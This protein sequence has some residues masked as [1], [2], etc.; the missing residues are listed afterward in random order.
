MIWSI[1]VGFV[2]GLL[3][4]AIKPGA[5][6]MGW[7]LTILLGIVGASVGNFIADTLGI[8]VNGGFAG[9]MPSVVG[10]IIVLFIYEFFSKRSK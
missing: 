3:A 1:I 9:L 8:Q 2:V 6:S 10:A 4:R 5:D 7:I